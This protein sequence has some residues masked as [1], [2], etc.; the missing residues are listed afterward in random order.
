MDFQKLAD[1]LG[2]ELAEFKELAEL[3]VDT[4]MADLTQATTAIHAKD[5]ETAAKAIH[6]IKGASGNL[7]F[8]DIHET[9]KRIEA[10]IRNNRLDAVTMPL[11]QVKEQ[12]QAIAAALNP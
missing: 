10:D 5:T 6:S 3:F 7:G 8:M 1:D 12:I 9:T 11:D 2:F 4:A